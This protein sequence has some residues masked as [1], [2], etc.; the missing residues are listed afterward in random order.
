MKTHHLDVQLCYFNKIKN[1]SKTVEGRVGEVDP[2]NDINENYK[3]GVTSYN[4][5]DHLKFT[6][7][8]EESGEM[9]MCEITQLEF[10][11]SFE[12]MLS[13]CGLDQCLP[14]ISDLEEGV[15]IYRSFPN[16]ANLEKDYG[17]VGIHI[18]LL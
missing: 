5:G 2:S 18:K 16:Y 13:G 11:A 12:E 17:A 7:S 10:F 15:R 1:G 3:A 8:S 4:V 14:G 6:I 9:V